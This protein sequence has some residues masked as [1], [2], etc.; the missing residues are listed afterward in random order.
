MDTTAV[1][2]VT[3]TILAVEDRG[4]RLLVEGMN[5]ILLVVQ[6]DITMRGNTVPAVEGQE[7]L[8]VMGVLHRNQEDT[9]TSGTDNTATMGGEG[10]KATAIGN[11]VALPLHPYGLTGSVLSY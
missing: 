4:L 11:C 2:D 1:A 8:K 6:V 5:I 7:A 9:R 3:H 10:E